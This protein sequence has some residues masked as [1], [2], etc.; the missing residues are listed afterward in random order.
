MKKNVAKKVASVG[1]GLSLLLSG[2]GSLN[3]E[4][5]TYKIGVGTGKVTSVSKGTSVTNVKGKDISGVYSTSTKVS[6]FKLYGKNEYA[7]V[8]MIQAEKLTSNKYTQKQLKDG[9]KG[10]LKEELSGG[11]YGNYA[12]QFK[13]NAKYTKVKADYSV[14]RNYGGILSVRVKYW[15]TNTKAKHSKF[16]GA[17]N[18]NLNTKAKNAN[19]DYVQL[20]DMLTVSKGKFNTYLKGATKKAYGKSASYPEPL[21]FPYYFDRD[22]SAVITY[23]ARYVGK[24]D[25]NVY[26]VRV[27][28]KYIKY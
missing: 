14:K 6:Q 7:K 8:D 20:N 21:L 25:N 26:L 28:K 24:K 11:V 3:A 19:A 10:F 2:V 17:M 27:P 4:A 16:I 15:L 1:L 5:S 13:K 12:N 18:Y 9:V 22:G 23:T